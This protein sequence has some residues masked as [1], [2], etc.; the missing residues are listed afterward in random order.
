MQGL[1][2]E[3]STGAAGDMILAALLDCG[4]SV[5][6]LKK[7][8]A[9][10]PLE[11]YTLE[12][13]HVNKGN[14]Q[15]RQIKIC[16]KEKQPLRNLPEITALVSKANLPFPVKEKSI[17][18]FQAL[19]RAEARVHGVSPDKVHFHEV[20]AVDSIIDIVGC[21]VALEMLGIEKILCSPL[22][23]GKGWTKAAHG[24]IPLPAPATMEIIKEHRIP[25]YG[26]SL[27]A[28]TV[29]PTGAALLGTLSAGFEPLPS[30]VI[31]NIGYGAGTKDFAR[32]NVVRAFQGLFCTGASPA[33]SK[34][35]SAPG[36]LLSEP[37]GILEAN[38]DDLNPEIY[39]YVLEKLFSAGALDVY[40]TPIQMKKN[41][42]AIKITVLANRQNT[43]QLGQILL[44]ETTTLGYRRQYAE[45]IMLPREAST[46]ET[47]WGPV[48]VVLGGWPPHYHNIAPEHDDCLRIA[49]EQGLPLKKIYQRI[50]RS[51]NRP[52][53]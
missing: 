4:L 2:L 26:L 24:W 35:F 6:E 25:C 12:S 29:T 27:E 38:I 22:P 36:E 1:Y 10:L 16:V 53:Y 14:L 31:E 43:D 15:A 46:I 48:K 32:P 28:E 33:D 39:N 21:I 34:N 19:A 5:D 45:K 13:K 47:P 41:R 3:C 49:R 50:W 17:A 30:M 18:A 7:Q 42:P 8:L 9:L 20:G 37:I 44:Q 40:F 52:L 23:L 11:G 51:I